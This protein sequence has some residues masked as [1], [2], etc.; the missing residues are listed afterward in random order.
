LLLLVSVATPFYFNHL[1][2]VNESILTG[3]VMVQIALIGRSGHLEIF[4]KTAKA[5]TRPIMLEYRDGI[6]SGIGTTV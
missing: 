1:W 2:L 4:R 5:A 6:S 3:F